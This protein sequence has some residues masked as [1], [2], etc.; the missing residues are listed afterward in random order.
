[1]KPQLELIPLGELR[2]WKSR[3]HV[4]VGLVFFLLGEVFYLAL[5]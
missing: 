4:A 3:F 2:I 1:M 5:R